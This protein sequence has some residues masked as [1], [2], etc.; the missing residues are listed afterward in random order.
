M[1]WLRPQS[2]TEYE[3]TL[4]CNTTEAGARYFTYP[5]S[6]IRSYFIYFLSEGAR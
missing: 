4:R 3:D 6:Y 2:V 5:S 1:D